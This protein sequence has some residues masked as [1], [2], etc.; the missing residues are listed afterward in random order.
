MTSKVLT[1]GILENYKDHFFR[2]NK[3]LSKIKLNVTT[4]KT[5]MVIH[6]RPGQIV[7]TKFFTKKL[8]T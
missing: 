5:V 6:D 8:S 2:F 3:Y 7:F 4:T 1:V